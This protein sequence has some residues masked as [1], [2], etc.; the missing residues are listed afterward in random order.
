MGRG[1]DS[2]TRTS[3]C[4]RRC[5]TTRRCCTAHGIRTGIRSQQSGRMDYAFTKR[6]P[7]S[8]FCRLQKKKKLIESTANLTQL[9]PYKAI[10]N[11]TKFSNEFGMEES[12]CYHK[13]TIVTAKIF[14]RC[15]IVYGKRKNCAAKLFFEK[16]VQLLVCLSVPKVTSLRN[17]AILYSL[18]LFPF[19]SSGRE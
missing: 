4:S 12:R 16:C 15:R 10:F 14:L 9:N 2:T 11:P 13:K 17:S 1:K 18:I 19:Y 5:G 3:I 6:N 8:I 7:Y